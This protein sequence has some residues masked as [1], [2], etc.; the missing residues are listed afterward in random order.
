MIASIEYYSKPNVMKIAHN[1]Q[2]D[3]LR[4]LLSA[5]LKEVEDIMLSMTQDSSSTLN[6]LA[7]YLISAGGKRLRSMLS[8]AIGKLVGC[9]SV[10]YIS[11]A[12]AVE[13][14]HGATLLHD[15]VIDNTMIRRAKKTANKIWGNKASILVGDY[16]FG[17]AF[18]L[19]VS[20]GS[21]EALHL[22]ANA[23]ISMSEAEVWQLDLIGKYDLS[24]AD[25]IK[26]ITSKTARLFAA[27]CASPGY[28]AGCT[29][30]EIAMLEGYGTSLG[31]SFQIIDDVLDYVSEDKKFG[32]S[33]GS[34]LKEKKVTLPF[35]L[36]YEEASSSD[37][38]ALKDAIKQDYTEDSLASVLSLF[39]KYDSIQRSIDTANSFIDKSLGSLDLFPDH[40]IK[41]VL[42]RLLKALS[43][44][45]CVT[46]LN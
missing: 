31:I 39:S 13:L 35:I 20:T 42:Q 9:K 8:I 38:K 30:E 3:D 40:E 32:K 37:R 25:Y 15:D 1:S 34:D 23:S 6:D 17:H 27:S 41:A 33:V 16:L 24:R 43:Q 5:E 21:I 22:L 11:L 10:H 45:V 12:T 26:L 44:Q 18:K 14:I 28:I 2:M 29:A 46:E 19:M 7:K 4:V 36:A